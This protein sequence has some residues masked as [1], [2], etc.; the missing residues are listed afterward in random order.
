MILPKLANVAD[1]ARL[2]FAIAHAI[3]PNAPA[4]PNLSLDAFV[5]VKNAAADLLA[6]EQPLVV[7]G[8]SSASEELLQAAANI[9]QALLI[10]GKKAAITLVVPEVNSLG[11]SLLGGHSLE[12][13]LALLKKGTTDTVIIA[14]NDLYRR[15]PA[16]VVDAALQTVGLQGFERR[17]VGSLSSGQFQRVMFARMLVQDA[18][19]ILLDEPFNAVDAKTTARLLA[20]VRQWHQEQRTVIAVLHDDAQV[21]QY[22]PQTLLLARELVAWG[23]TG[24]VLTEANLQ[25]ARAMAEAWDETAEVCELD[26]TPDSHHHPHAPAAHPVN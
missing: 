3:D 4:V 10:H 21:R 9:V 17:A 23:P 5:W 8:T 13:A 11:V 26:I 16:T 2:G 15:L 12:D 25:R 14:E 24:D 6:A 1:Q 20:L 7:A 22:F 19:L 18:Q